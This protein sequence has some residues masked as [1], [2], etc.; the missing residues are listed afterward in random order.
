MRTTLPHHIG[1]AVAR[2]DQLLILAWRGCC[3][4]C[5][6]ARAPWLLPWLLL[7]LLLLLHGGGDSVED[8]LHEAVQG[9]ENQC[10]ELGRL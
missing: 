8:G 9:A 5:W 2:T 10:I 3:P 1:S 7:L 6:A 4:G